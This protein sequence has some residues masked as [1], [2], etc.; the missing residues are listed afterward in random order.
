MVAV[1]SRARAEEHKQSRAVC[2]GNQS[3]TCHSSGQIILRIAGDEV[4][5]EGTECD[6]HRGWLR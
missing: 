6:N 3:E 4:I 2:G 1:A 5:I